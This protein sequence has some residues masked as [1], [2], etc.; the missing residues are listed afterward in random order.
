[1]DTPGP[2]RMRALSVLNDVLTD[3]IVQLASAP[4]DEI[5]ALRAQAEAVTERVIEYCADTASMAYL[6]PEEVAAIRSKLLELG[7][8]MKAHIARIVDLRLAQFTCVETSRTRH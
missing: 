6:P 7:A 4:T 3:L 1:M 8:A 5:P 2:A